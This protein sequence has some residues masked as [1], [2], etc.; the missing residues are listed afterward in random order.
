MAELDMTNKVTCENWD[1]EFAET[2]EGTLTIA[3][4]VGG[5]NSPI[6]RPRKITGAAG[7]TTTVELLYG[8][9][10]L[11]KGNND[12]RLTK[13]NSTKF[14]AD[15]VALDQIN[16]VY[17][18]GAKGNSI[19]QQSVPVDLTAAVLNRGARDVRNWL[20]ASF[21]AQISAAPVQTEGGDFADGNNTLASPTNIVTGSVGLDILV[22][23]RTMAV[24]SRFQPCEGLTSGS[25]WVVYMNPEDIGT[26]RKQAGKEANTYF[27]LTRALAYAER[28]GTL[29]STDMLGSYNS[30]ELRESIYCPAGRGFFLGGQAVIAQWGEGFGERA[31][32]SFNEILDATIFHAKF[33]SVLGI[34]KTQFDTG[35]G[36]KDFGVIAMKFGSSSAAAA[37]K[38]AA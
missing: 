16:Y 18:E 29:L 32:K 35:D 14:A 3:D 34:K 22:D 25:K 30:I 38:R 31:F 36:L 6:Y 24:K 17:D 7:N 15:Y 13:N 9:G 27:D 4:L 23:A 19:E 33:Y 10:K 11:V 1:K 2:V 21:F 26:L 28:K 37:T 20:T 8:G 5:F 12:S